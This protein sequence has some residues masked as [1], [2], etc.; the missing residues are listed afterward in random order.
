MWFV[1][2]WISLPPPSF[3]C[4]DDVRYDADH[5]FLHSTNSSSSTGPADKTRQI[6]VNTAVGEEI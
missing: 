4:C 3:W 1:F 2:C 5:V 6:K